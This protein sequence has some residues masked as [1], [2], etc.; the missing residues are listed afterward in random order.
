MKS[1]IKYAEERVK[2]S[3]EELKNSKTEDKKLYE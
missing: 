3:F 1:K 2:S